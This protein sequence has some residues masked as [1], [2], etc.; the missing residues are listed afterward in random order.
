[1]E[2]KKDMYSSQD[3]ERLYVDYQSEWVPRGMTLRAYC[4]RN[5]VPIKVMENF[6]RGI[7][8][9]IV[10]VDVVGRPAT[11]EPP[12]EEPSTA[13]TPAP[14]PTTIRTTRGPKD[15]K[16][17]LSVVIRFGNGTEVSHRDLDYTG[18]KL[19]IDKLVVLCS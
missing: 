17:R 4:T 13:T 12:A 5:N 18:L 19:L 8:K 1:M 14:S 15:D 2:P 7:H 16:H 10:E 3:L 9:R 6:V 11:E